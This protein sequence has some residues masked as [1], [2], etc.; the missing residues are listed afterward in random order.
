MTHY[1]ASRSK[2]S[3]TLK[4]PPSKSHTM[5]AILFAAM[6]EGSSTLHNALPSPDRE[7]MVTACRALGATIIE[8]G[9]TL[10]ID[11]V[12]SQ[13]RLPDDIID[14]GN[15]GQVLRFIGALAALIEGHTLFTGDHS[16]RYNRPMQ[17]LMD[18]LTALGANC[19]STKDDGRA[20]LII[21]GPIQAGQ[22]EL[23]GHD[24]QP[25]SGLIIAA[26]F[27]D[28]VT[29]I[30]VRE[31]GEQPWVGMTL[32]WLDKFNIPYQNDAYRHY[33]IEGGKVIR[34]FDYSVPGDFSS[35]AF[36][37]V[38][39][40][41]TQ[42]EIT[43]EGID[44]DDPQGDKILI[45]HLQRMGA[46]IAL[47]TDGLRVKASQQL[48][49]IEIDVNDCIDAVPILA[50]A[51]CFADSPTRLTNAAIARKKESD[52]LSMI[53]AELSK[54]GAKIE[55]FEDSLT[56]HPSA[57]HAATVEAHADHRIAMALTV[58]AL[59]IEE[60]THIEGI[61]CIEKSY[62]NF[63]EDMKALGAS[64]DELS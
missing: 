45:E 21:K 59:T 28:G 61:E 64:I 5:R 9:N 2:L 17:P 18:G 27:L 12:A 54:M 49:G 24:S 63:A 15:S 46:N 58:A 20:P 11:G 44:F 1:L 40:V 48:H 14:V 4:A 57:L 34:G 38:A 62:P 3:G 56:I 41:I 52:R 6:A 33:R 43:I 37:L 13:P 31:P 8:D 53:T 39:A 23:D 50:V 55:E 26:C 19:I 51:A 10:H 32:H 36:P 35:L 60:S 29:D 30:T 16:V 25:V 22:T 7:A 47:K 42:S